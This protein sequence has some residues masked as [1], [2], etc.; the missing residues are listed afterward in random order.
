MEREYIVG[1]S[2]LVGRREKVAI[3]NR[4]EKYITESCSSSVN[5]NNVN[6]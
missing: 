5:I 4:S 2:W 3:D 6:T 1:P